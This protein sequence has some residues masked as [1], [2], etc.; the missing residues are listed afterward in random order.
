LPVV[1]L[2]CVE[3]V[4]AVTDRSDEAVVGGACS[5]M[6]ARW[7]VVVGFRRGDPAVLCCRLLWGGPSGFFG[8]D[9]GGGEFGEQLGGFSEV[10]GVVA[11]Y[12]PQRLVFGGETVD[13]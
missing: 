8:D 6:T 3:L 13:L 9:E 1:V 4:D 12:R 11:E 2:A 5:R 10:A 7:G